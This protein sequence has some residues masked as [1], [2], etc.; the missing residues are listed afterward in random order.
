MSP[1]CENCGA[2]VSAEYHRV[3]SGNDG[4][5]HGCPSCTSPATRQREAAGLEADYKVRTD[6]EGRTVVDRGGEA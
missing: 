1:Q 5:L 2:H 4:V 3:R 6:A